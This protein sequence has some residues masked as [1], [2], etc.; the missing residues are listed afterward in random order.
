MPFSNHGEMSEIGNNRKFLLPGDLV[1][2]RYVTI[3]VQLERIEVN[4]FRLGSA[5]E[6]LAIFIRDLNFQSQFYTMSG[7]WVHKVASNVKFFVPGFVDPGELDDILPYLPQ[8]E[9]PTELEDMLHSFKS[10]LPRNIGKPLIKKMSD[11]WAKADA[12]YQ[13]AAS[14]LDNA[15]NIVA[16]PTKI[17]FATLAEIAEKAESKEKSQQPFSPKLLLRA[18]VATTLCLVFM[19]CIVVCFAKKSGSELNDTAIFALLASS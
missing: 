9:V 2:L 13:K 1:E 6:E 17:S 5:Q 14:R 4:V 15:H 11:F 10:V 3:L 12:V 7:R 18:K 16:H 8:V 19:L